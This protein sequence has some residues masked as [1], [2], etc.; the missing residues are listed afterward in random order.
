[1]SGS[2][3]GAFNVANLALLL[4]DQARLAAK[5]AEHAANEAEALVAAKAEPDFQM[6][7]ALARPGSVPVRAVVERAADRLALVQ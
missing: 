7:A 4:L 3:S 5:R 6:V 2:G 1:M